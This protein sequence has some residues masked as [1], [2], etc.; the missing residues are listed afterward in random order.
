MRN[1][2]TK[3]LNTIGETYFEHLKAALKFS[4]HLFTAAIA[5]TVHAFLP[6]LFEHT[7]GKKV[8][9]IVTLMK[10]SQRWNKLDTLCKQDKKG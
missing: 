3:H 7:A 8:H 10:S 4:Y 9:H 2:F 5:C 6:F 1:Y